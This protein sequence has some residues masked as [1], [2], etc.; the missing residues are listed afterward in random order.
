MVA[1]LTL[2]P[3]TLFLI[4]FFPACSAQPRVIISIS[5]AIQ[6]DPRNGEAGY[7]TSVWARPYLVCFLSLFV[8]YLTS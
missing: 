8:F 4:D 7:E 3:A 1:I 5:V 2:P 6:C